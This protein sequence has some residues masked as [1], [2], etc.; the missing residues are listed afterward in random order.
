MMLGIESSGDEDHFTHQ[1]VVV[2]VVD[3]EPQREVSFFFF[4]NSGR[5]GIGR[6]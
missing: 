4:C 2:I 1:V 6:C 3:W 5:S